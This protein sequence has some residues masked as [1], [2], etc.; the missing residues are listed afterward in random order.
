MTLANL[1][2]L[3]EFLGGIAVIVSLIYLALQIRQN[4]KTIRGSTLQQN[5]DFWGDLFLRLAQP[6]LANVY[7]TGMKG[8]ADISPITFTQFNCLA[9]SMFLGFENQYFQYRNGIL[10]PESY[11]GYERIIAAQILA[12]RGFR[13]YWEQNRSYYSPSFVSHIDNIIERTPEGGA[14]LKDWIVIASR[15]QDD[16]V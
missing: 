15:L 10:D 4:T 7:S 3:G 2:N 14:L 16:K 5:T 11:L 9:R 1:A 13:I 6:D 12:F 8:S